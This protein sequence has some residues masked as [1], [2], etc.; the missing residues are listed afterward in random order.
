[1]LMKNKMNL[2]I[3]GLFIL[4]GSFM[5]TNFVAA[6]TT[7]TPSP[8]FESR[9]VYDIQNNQAILFGGGNSDGNSIELEMTWLFSSQNQS[10]MGLS[11]ITSPG[12][13]WAHSM[14]YNSLTGKIL[15]FGGFSTVLSTR[16]NDMWEF[17]PTTNEWTELYPTVSPSARSAH[18]MYFDPVFNEIILFGG[19]LNG[20]T[21]TD[22]TWIYNCTANT[23]YQIYPPTHP[24]I[25]Y[26][27]TFA[28]D[29]SLQ[30]G[31]FYA[32]R[33]ISLNSDAWLFNRSSFTWTVQYS[34]SPR[35]RYGTT[36]VY[37]P[38]DTNFIMF[39]G[40]NEQSPIRALDDTWVFDAS[41]FIWTE[42]ETTASPPPRSAHS[43]TFD[44]Y[45]GKVLLFGG[46]GED[47]TKVYGDF[48]NYDPTI[49]VWSQEFSSNSL[50][51]PTLM[52]ILLFGLV[53]IVGVTRLR[54]VPL[55]RQNLRKTK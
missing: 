19:Y 18:G 32:G 23:W 10:W 22:D 54:K 30:V 44:R 8:R 27:H 48:W 31:V 25:R 38:I 46:Y 7:S 20:D 6:D 36:I 21:H 26:G 5:L 35:I 4:I 29:E 9:M 34:S 52:W 16:V 40:D 41:S 17:D 3:I 28:Y 49:M 42:I 11:S 13:R 14:I 12:S 2:A 15:L 45:L 37:N 39:G 43:T 47:Y 50:G 51:S 1:M 33:D 53:G 55:V 24:S